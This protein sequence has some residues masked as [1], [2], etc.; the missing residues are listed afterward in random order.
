MNDPL[1]TSCQRATVG[2]GLNDACLFGIQWSNSELEKKDKSNLV[3]KNLLRVWSSRFLS[4]S[5]SISRLLA[6]SDNWRGVRYGHTGYGM[7]YISNFYIRPSRNW[8]SLT[9]VSYRHLPVCLQQEQ[10]WGEFE[11]F[12]NLVRFR[13]R[14][15]TFS[16]IFQFYKSL[17]SIQ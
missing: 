13:K 4:R 15:K 14:I 5:S 8:C 16:I 7:R 10:E 3:V 6:K 12:S 9:L 17:F 11:K 2:N 1:K